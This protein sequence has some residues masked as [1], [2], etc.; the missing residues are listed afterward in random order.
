[1]TTPSK[2]TPSK[3]LTATHRLLYRG[4]LSLPDSYLPLDGLSFVTKVID[5]L[6]SPALLN[7]TLALTLESMRGLPLYLLETVKVKETYI[8]PPGDIFVDIHPDATLTRIYFEN[9]FCLA[10]VTS[11]TSRT[12][13]G[14]R[15]SLTENNDPDTPDLLIYGELRDA[16]PSEASIPSTSTASPKVLVLLAARILPGPPPASSFRLPRPDDPTPRRPPLNFSAKRKRDAAGLPF[17]LTAASSDA[18]KRVRI[19]AGDKGKGKALSRDGDEEAVRRA[20]VE[21]MLRMPKPPLGKQVSVKALGKDARVGPKKDV[22]KVPNVPERAG[23]RRAGQDSAGEPDVFGT[24]SGGTSGVV[25]GDVVQTVEKENKASLVSLYAY[26]LGRQAVKKAVTKAL[27]KH[28]ISRTDAEFKELFQMCYHGASFALVRGQTTSYDVYSIHVAALEATYDRCAHRRAHDRPLCRRAHQD[29]PTRRAFMSHL[30]T[31]YN[32][33][34]TVKDTGRMT[35]DVLQVHI[36]TYRHPM[37]PLA[38]DCRRTPP[39]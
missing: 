1:M 35:T 29:V 4:S 9:V 15:V 2:A 20:A 27:G 23:S 26:G 24:V 3:A 21:T 39:D 18:G 34:L 12:E 36:A 37:P 38:Q 7:N 32:E 5:A 33:G 22:F 10:P 31:A 13:Y 6:S 19:T 17:D 11:P 30:E 16:S 14:V 28:G 8:D 25:T